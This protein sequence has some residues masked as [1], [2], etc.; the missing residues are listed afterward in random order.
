MSFYPHT[1]QLGSQSGI[2]LNPP[3]DN[4]DGFI[5]QAT[6]QT[7]QFTG[8]FSRG[9]IDVPFKVNRA[10][11]KR[12]LG[13]PQSVRVSALNEAYVQLHEAINNGARE[14]VISRLSV[15]GATNKFA[16]F[17]IDVSGVGSFTAADTAPTTN[18][19]FYLKDM[20][21]YNDGVLFEVN[22]IRALDATNTA[23]ATKR[24]TLRIKEPD[25]T[26]RYEVTGLLDDTSKDG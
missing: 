15:A 17:N 7:V 1:R 6:D 16:V 13:A 2:Q 4:T 18:Y 5:T 8:R 26:V 23:I 20:E 9:R 12:K 10:N 11:Y 24:V 19:V 25:G 3:R 22:A 14:A 21:C